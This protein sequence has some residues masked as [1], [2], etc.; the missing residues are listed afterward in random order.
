MNLF[1]R[2]A[3]TGCFIG[4]MPF[5]P[6]TFGSL[7]AVTLYWC[8]PASETSHFVWLIALVF[9]LGVWA[10]G[11]I[12]KASGIK[13][14]AIIVID[15]ITGQ[16]ITLLFVAKSLKWLAI[17][18]FLFR[19]FDIIKP[20]PAR[21]AEKLKAG[22]GVMLDDVVAGVYAAGCLQVLIFLLD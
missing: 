1:A 17:G 14:N 3:A 11:R 16:F 5:A 9:F 4:F 6:G 21:R 10:A 20:F 22:W 8:I 2:I 18:L 19:L 15:E 12:E 13:D 7:F